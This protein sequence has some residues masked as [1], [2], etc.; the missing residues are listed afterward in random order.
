LTRRFSKSTLT[1]W[2]CLPTSKGISS[3]S[4]QARVTVIQHQ[5]ER[6]KAIGGPTELHEQ[7]LL[8]V[9]ESVHLM[10]AHVRRSTPDPIAYRCYLMSGES[11][12]AVRIFDAA[13]DAEVLIR[14]GRFLKQ[15]P[16]HVGMEVWCGKRLVTRLGRG[17]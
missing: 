5:I 11:I 15:H 6:L 2:N 1:G 10:Q 7:L 17:A 14:A 16:E 13:D 12:R 3:A 4:A 8:T 9:E